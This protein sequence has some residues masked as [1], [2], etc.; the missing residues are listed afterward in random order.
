LRF[1]ITFAVPAGPPE[2]RIAAGHPD[3]ESPLLA[4]VARTL[5]D[6]GAEVRIDARGD[7][8]VRRRREDEAHGPAIVVEAQGLANLLHELVHIVRAGVLADDHGIDYGEF[9]FRIGDVRYRGI[10][11]DE[12]AACVVSCAYLPGSDEDIDDWFAEQIETQP[13]FFGLGPPE[14]ARRLDE[15]CQGPSARDV[16]VAVDSAYAG[17]LRWLREAGA[18]PALALPPRRPSFE[19]LWARFRARRPAWF[20]V[21]AACLV[22]P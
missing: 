3:A 19:A 12:L 2:P 5:G 8:L 9:P 11:W 4:A 15:L 13:L 18:P 16:E 20:D 10:L 22:G 21:P 6:R 14:F 17:V 1:G 7:N